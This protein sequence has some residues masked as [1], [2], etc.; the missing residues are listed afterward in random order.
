ML[1]K[2]GKDAFRDDLINH[3]LG[4]LLVIETRNWGLDSGFQGQVREGG[5]TRSKE[6]RLLHS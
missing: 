3:T 1:G 4:E 5:E 6:W 2:R